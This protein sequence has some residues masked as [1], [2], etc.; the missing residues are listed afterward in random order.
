M[1]HESYELIDFNS[2]QKDSIFNKSSSEYKL[3]KSLKPQELKE[4]INTMAFR[5]IIIE[6]DTN[7]VSLNNLNNGNT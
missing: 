7:H 1:N 2:D 4:Y 5:G 3:I 6:I